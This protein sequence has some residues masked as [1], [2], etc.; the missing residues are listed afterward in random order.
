MKIFYQVI[1][2]IAT[3]VIY[4]LLGVTSTDEATI[5]VQA[6]DAQYQE[7]V[8]EVGENAANFLMN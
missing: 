8:R 4:M 2:V 3:V 7:L 5:N 1:I 6:H